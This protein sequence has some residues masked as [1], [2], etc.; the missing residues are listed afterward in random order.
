MSNV[1]IPNGDQQRQQ[2]LRKIGVESFEELL[3]SIPGQLRFMEKLDLPDAASELDLLRELTGFLENSK[4]AWWPAK[5]GHIV[6][7]LV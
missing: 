3:T 7:L 4:L 1:Y 2:M 5:I 6:I